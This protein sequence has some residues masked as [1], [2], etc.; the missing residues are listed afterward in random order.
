MYIEKDSATRKCSK[1]KVD[2]QTDSWQLRLVAGGT[3]VELQLQL[4]LELLLLLALAAPAGFNEP[5]QEEQTL[6]IEFSIFVLPQS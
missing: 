2:L 6:L 4:E 1:F 5:K 3:T